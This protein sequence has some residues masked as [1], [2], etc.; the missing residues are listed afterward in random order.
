MLSPATA[1]ERSLPFVNIFSAVEVL[2]WIEMRNAIHFYNRK[3]DCAAEWT[4]GF[5][6]SSLVALF[7]FEFTYV[8]HA[9]W[10]PGLLAALVLYLLLVIGTTLPTMLVSGVL[11]N[12]TVEKQVCLLVKV[13]QNV[14]CHSLHIQSASA[15]VTSD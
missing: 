7:V 6:C 4:V 3:S 5:V 14:A 1:A 11:L 13:R 8:M 10:H 2:A 9:D 12:Q 15:A